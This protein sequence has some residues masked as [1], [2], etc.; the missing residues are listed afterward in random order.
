MVRPNIVP[1]NR[2]LGKQE[3]DCLHLFA[4]G[5]SAHE[6]ALKKHRSEFSINS[7]LRSAK[8]KLQAKTLAHAIFRAYE[9]GIFP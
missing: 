3:W 2:L 6:I 9:L 7:Y 8:D 4:G 1:E 5:K